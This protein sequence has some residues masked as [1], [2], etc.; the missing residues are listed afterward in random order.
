[1]SHSLSKQPIITQTSHHP[2]RQLGGV[3]FIDTYPYF[4]KTLQTQ[5]YKFT[6]FNP[7]MPRMCVFFFPR[8]LV[9]AGVRRRRKS[10][11]ATN[12]SLRRRSSAN[13]CNPTM[14]RMCAF[15]FSTQTRAS[16]VA[17]KRKKQ[18][19]GLRRIAFGG[20]EEEIRTLEPLL[21]VTRFP[22][23]RPRPN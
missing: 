6:T 11:Q 21:T 14:L 16:A 13:K 17:W 23:A 10:L 5:H 1:M 12:I 2:H 9:R 15:F 22:V 20:G 4:L 19:Y 18:P 3:I 8:K 7:T